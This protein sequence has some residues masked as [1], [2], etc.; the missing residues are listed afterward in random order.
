MTNAPILDPKRVL[1]A[2]LPHIMVPTAESQIVELS[3]LY[4]SYVRVATGAGR[5]IVQ[6]ATFTEI[7]KGYCRELRISARLEGNK[8][9]LEGVQIASFAKEP[10]P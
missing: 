5:E 7:V 8:V 3:E 10:R 1:V 9:Y 2:T 4:V 6:F